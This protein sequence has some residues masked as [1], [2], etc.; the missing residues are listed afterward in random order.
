MPEKENP[1]EI[2]GVYQQ[3]GAAMSGLFYVAILFTIRPRKR[4]NTGRGNFAGWV[5]MIKFNI[6]KM[7]GSLTLIRPTAGECVVVG[8]Y[9]W[10]TSGHGT[11]T[12]IV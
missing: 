6:F 12:I 1:A 9:A 7:L 2:N 3:P 4:I 10:P 8:K 5:E 11:E